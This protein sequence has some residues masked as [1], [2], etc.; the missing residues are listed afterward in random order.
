MRI[1]RIHEFRTADNADR[2]FRKLPADH[3]FR[4]PAAA[5]RPDVLGA[6]PV[7]LESHVRDALPDAFLALRRHL[8]R[9]L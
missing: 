8:P 9:H 2:L 5:G 3:R 1:P 4:W 7:R 6:G